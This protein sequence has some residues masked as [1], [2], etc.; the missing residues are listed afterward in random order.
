M[1]YKVRP[2]IAAGVVALFIGVLSQTGYGSNVRVS[3]NRALHFSN[4]QLKTG[5]RLHYAEQGD[6]SGQVIVMLHGFTDSWFSYSR[7][8]PLIDPKYHVYVVDQRGHGNSDRPRD[9]YTP[10]HFADD[11]L[12]FMELKGLKDVTIVGHSMGSFVAQYVA[13]LAPERVSNLVL[14]G[15]ARSV[16]NNA[17]KELQ[18]AINSLSDSVSEEFVRDFQN[19]MLARPVPEE[20]MNGV[21]K[22]ARSC[23]LVFGKR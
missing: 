8:M 19:S 18:Q 22:E 2:I 4:V 16:R 1:R 20:F 15:S 12:A 11:V 10:R 5:I 7:V 14:I 17:V 6:R 3:G 23:R 9:G 21:V 13:A